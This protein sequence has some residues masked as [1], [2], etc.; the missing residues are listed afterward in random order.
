MKKLILL[1][2]AVVFGLFFAI[3]G[4]LAKTVWKWTDEKGGVHYS[5]DVG[6]IPPKYRSKAQKIELEDNKVNKIEEKDKKPPPKTKIE[7]PKDLKGNTEAHWKAKAQ[8]AKL[9][10]KNAEDRVAGA[11]E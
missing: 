7:E 11:K 1:L 9:A 4:A 3:E 10:V 2:T 8:A 5:D 6:S